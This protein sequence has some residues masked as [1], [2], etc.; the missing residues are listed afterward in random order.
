MC[1]DTCECEEYENSNLAWCDTKRSSGGAFKMVGVS[2]DK[3]LV[4]HIVG[5]PF[6]CLRLLMVCVPLMS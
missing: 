2:V 3:R 4:F 6:T 5:P 1:G